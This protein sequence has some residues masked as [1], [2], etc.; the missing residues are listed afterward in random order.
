MT[1]S[2]AD[3]PALSSGGLHVWTA[4]L[5]EDHRATAD[6]LP[7]LSDE[8]RAQAAQFAFERD[9]LRFIQAHGMVR[10]ILAHYCDADPAALAFSRNR[11]GKP[12]LV[13]Q[14]KDRDVQFSLTHSGAC[15]MLAVRLDG[16]IG[17]DVEK[18]RDLPRSIDIARTRFT[19][20]ESGVLANLRETARRDAF[21][22]L[23]THKEATVKG[24]GLGLAGNIGRVEFDLDS[25]DAPRL[26]SWDGDRSM[27]QRWFAIRL[28][29]TPGYV[30]A[31]AGVRPIGAL[32]FRSWRPDG[33]D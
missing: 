4:C 9:R 18:V 7:I 29:A 5:V 23:W 33:V 3:E 25:I 14:G 30:A 26:V 17:I 8:E 21:F 32:T 27:A 12:H 28:D 2:G 11:H 19:P 6:L 22:V 16:A 13:S 24:L 10:Q 31:V 15:C 20:A 1:F